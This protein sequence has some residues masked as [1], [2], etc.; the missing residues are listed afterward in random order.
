MSIGCHGEV[1][2]DREGSGEVRTRGE[3]RGEL[4]RGPVGRHRDPPRD[5][6]GVRSPAGLE[7]QLDDPALEGAQGGRHRV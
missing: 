5:G 6:K 2:F 4:F 1:R 7:S 3:P